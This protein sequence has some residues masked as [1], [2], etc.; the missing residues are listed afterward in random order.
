[1]QAAG[2]R[3]EENCAKTAFMAIINLSFNG[4]DQEKHHAR[5]YQ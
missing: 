1:M 3:A 5:H 2:F 4:T